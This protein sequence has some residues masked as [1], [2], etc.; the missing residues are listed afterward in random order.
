[1]AKHIIAPPHGVN[2]RV[3]NGGT[4]DGFYYLEG[5]R[6]TRVLARLADLQ[7]DAQGRR[8]T[9]A[10][11]DRVIQ[12]LWE[13]KLGELHQTRPAKATD[14]PSRNI[15]ELF[16]EWIAAAAADKAPGTR[17][18]Y[19]RTTREY[20][21]AVGDHPAHKIGLAQVDRY[22]AYLAE[23]KL[24][25]A[26]INIRLQNLKTFLRWAHERDFIERIP[27]IRLLRREK[28]LARVLSEDDVTAWFRMLQA[29][30][31]H[32][33]GRG[34]VR[35]PNGTTFH[36]N[37]MQ[38]RSAALRERFLRVAYDTGCRSSEIFHLEL[39][40]FDL[41]QGLLRV[42]FK[43]RFAI[44]ERRE[45]VI[46]LTKRLR[47]FIAALRRCYPHERYLLDDGRGRLAYTSPGAFA[48]Q[49]QRNRAALGFNGR[50]V[51]LVHGFRALY[52]HRLRERG[53]PLDAIK[54]LLGHSDIKVT[55][56]YF[57]AS[58]TRERAAVALLDGP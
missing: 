51:K 3:R 5:R 44:K 43:Q 10:Q 23:R 49:L 1:M 48:P 31:R 54:N 57:P 38:R 25:V 2:Y 29:I 9:P 13:E 22:R 36:P 33:P 17:A 40:Q 28:R 16:G 6:T 41:K 37:R 24:S 47:R 50:G 42:E 56:G 15:G 46:P 12:R 21:A 53:A 30:R 19:A 34:P 7:R 8:R 20:L 18:Y 52:A 32:R 26:S 58:Q 4:V 55:E 39:A 35:L 45:K 14:E 27:K 11:L